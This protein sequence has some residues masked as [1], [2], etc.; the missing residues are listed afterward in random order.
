[1]ISNN[2]AYG[3]SSFR[4]LVY[5][6]NS[7]LVLTNNQIT[8]NI[9]QYPFH[10]LKY[11]GN[12]TT[13]NNLI[14]GNTSVPPSGTKATVRLQSDE[15]T[16]MEFSNNRIVNN[17]VQYSGG[18]GAINSVFFISPSTSNPGSISVSNNKIHGNTISSSDIGCSEC[19]VFYVERSTANSV[20]ISNNA[21]TGN[22]ATSIIT[23]GRRE[24]NVSG[25]YSAIPEFEN[26]NI[27]NNNI[28]FLVFTQNLQSTDY[29]LGSNWWGVS[30]SAEFDT[31]TY[32]WND[33]AT[34]GNVS[35]SSPLVSPSTTAPPAPP[36]NITAELDFRNIGLTWAANAESDIAGYKI[37]Y[38][39]DQSGYPYANSVDVGN[40]TTHTLSGLNTG[41]TYYTA[42]AA[43]DSGSDESWVSNES[44]LTTLNNQPVSADVNISTQ[45]DTAAQITLSA[46]DADGDTITFSILTQPTKGTLGEL[47]S[48]SAT[49]STVLYT[50]TA[51]VFGS[52]S[53]TYVVNDGT[54]NSSVSTVL[55]NISSV[56]DV[57]V[58]YSQEITPEE[59]EQ[60][61][62]TLTA[63]DGD[64]DTLTW[65]TSNLV[66]GKVDIVP[67]T[68]TATSM[69]VL[70][71]PTPG[72]VGIGNISFY[73][74]DPYTTSNTATVTI[75]INNPVVIEAPGISFKGL[76]TLGLSLLII[77]IVFMRR[78]RKVEY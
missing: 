73:V 61:R 7:S 33:D 4:V 45:E 29:T 8:N 54:I 23:P 77:L 44:S 15:N 35:Y 64:G 53:F 14:M 16:T 11:D 26:N 66:G 52:D 40:V 1:M 47:S 48:L 25:T 3:D 78:S 20:S 22:T 74:N 69:D 13:T 12:A 30:T 42:V 70:F 55:I 49:L 28:D 68:I 71:T 2:Y 57:P 41:T 50:P 18:S 67:N 75:N 43:Y 51:N 59:G 9:T 32:D 37:Y 34:L 17:T 21:I 58:V 36:T 65:A 38:D 24:S 39:T 5:G 31:L 46:S 6:Q 27:F 76:I 19:A 10:I 56:N 72:F 62:I 60:I 63:S